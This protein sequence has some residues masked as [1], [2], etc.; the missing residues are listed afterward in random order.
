M[1]IRGRATIWEDYD[2]VAL[3]REHGSQRAVSRA[4]GRAQGGLSEHL[5]QPGNEDLKRQCQAALKEHQAERRKI[6]PTPPAIEGVGPTAAVDIDLTRRVAEQRFDAKSE[7]SDKKASQRIRFGAG[8]VCIVFVG[9]QHIGNAG[10][11]VARMFG[12][13]AIVN[14][15]PSTY[16]WQMGDL[17]DNFIIGKL[18]AENMKPTLPVWE[19]WQL[20]KHYLKGFGDKLIAYTG[21]NHEAWGAMLTGV[22]YRR[23]IC[24]DGVLYDGDEIRATLE[25]GEHQY[26][27]WAR[28][29]WMGRSMYNP[30]HHLERA[31]RF[32]S[33][34]YDFYVGAHLHSGS[35]FREFI[36]ER[37]RKAAI[38]TGSYKVHD[39]F[40]TMV[41][42]PYSDAS[43][44]CAV[45]LEEDGSF[46]GCASLDMAAKYMNA[47]H[48]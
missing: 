15:M 12:E 28:H 27:V 3:H 6:P 20:A 22:D 10:A 36:L 41:G 7:R 48:G 31:A 13:Q 45:V 11:D 23:D 21:G 17:V 2:L 44:A 38:Q 47:M 18:M 42:F 43:T 9:D 26:R 24:P 37:E 34:R 1:R 29:K 39:D 40:A 30:T 5:S 16:V 33:A 19:Q 4:L 25:V 8:P 32:D 35:V 14:D 46:F